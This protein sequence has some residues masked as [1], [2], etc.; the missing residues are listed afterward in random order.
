MPGFCSSEATVF[1]ATVAAP[2]NH[3]AVTAA[4]LLKVSGIWSPSLATMEHG[5]ANTGLVHFVAYLKW[6]VPGG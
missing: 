6:E 4:E 1:G 2:M 5:R 3:G